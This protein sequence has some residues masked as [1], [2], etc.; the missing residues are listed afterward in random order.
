MFS[1]ATFLT[2][3]SDWFLLFRGFILS[4]GHL[5]RPTDQMLCNSSVFVSRV[6]F[7]KVHCSGTNRCPSRPGVPYAGAERH[8]AV[9]CHRT[10]LMGAVCT[11]ALQNKSVGQTVR[12]LP[13]LAQTY[14][15]FLQPQKFLSENVNYSAE[16]EPPLRKFD[17]L[18]PPRVNK[19]FVNHYASGKALPQPTVWADRSCF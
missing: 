1:F 12:S 7:E 5:L 11:D 10:C 17:H 9:H 3:K 16:S 8:Q 6:S 13:L 14:L 15:F 2:I 4:W 19:P 18:L